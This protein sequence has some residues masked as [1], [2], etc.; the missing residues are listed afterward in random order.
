MPINQYVAT[1]FYITENFTQSV[2]RGGI[3]FNLGLYITVELTAFRN[4]QDFELKQVS[5]RLES[6]A[7]LSPQIPDII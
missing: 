5:F 3:K 6:L 7:Y 4:T 1:V 2:K